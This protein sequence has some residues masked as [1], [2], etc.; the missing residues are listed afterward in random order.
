MRSSQSFSDCIKVVGSDSQPC[1]MLSGAEDVPGQGGKCEIFMLL[2]FGVQDVGCVS[3]L[4]KLA[5]LERPWDST[6]CHLF[7]RTM[8]AVASL[9]WTVMPA[10]CLGST[11]TR[12][13]KSDEMGAM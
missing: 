8:K 5:E 13:V 6:V 10:Q 12:S 1:D 11:A 7:V 4:G 3:S 9:L 2:P